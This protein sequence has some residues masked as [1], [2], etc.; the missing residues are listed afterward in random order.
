MTIIP[1]ATQKPM[2]EFVGR[3]GCQL[4]WG[5]NAAWQW[6]M[7]ISGL[8]MAIYRL[9]CF[10]YLFKKELNTK[11][12]A[13]LILVVELAVI[14][15]IVLSLY[16]LIDTF[17]GWESAIYFQF[18]MNL[19]P[20]EVK[21]ILRYTNRNDQIEM[22][23]FKMIRIVCL[24][25]GQALIML[26]LTIYAWILFNLWKHDMENHKNGIIT[27][28]MKKE[29]NQKNAI[30]LFGQMATF[31]VENTVA[32]YFSVHIANSSAEVSFLMPFAEIVVST[33]ISTIQLTTSHEMRRFLKKLFNIH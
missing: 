24:L 2:Y 4:Y 21:T 9:I 13:R 28:L 23:Y 30:T 11:K 32:I 18:C 19:G 3:T 27:E 33:T 26:E 22:S 6:L 17:F 14:V 10:H 25:F 5:V 31:V 29:R 7:G 20:A 12:I 16:T 1:I 15:V 8:G